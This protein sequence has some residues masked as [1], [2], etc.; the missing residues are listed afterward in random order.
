MPHIIILLY[1]D[2][3][4]IIGEYHPPDDPEM[5]GGGAMAQSFVTVD[6]NALDVA[7]TKAVGKH[8]DKAMDGITVTFKI[9]SR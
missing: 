4:N 1:D 8:V 7:I 2:D 9:K 5:G 6:L 3:G